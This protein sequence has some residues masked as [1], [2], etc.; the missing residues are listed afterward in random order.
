MCGVDFVQLELINFSSCVRCAAAAVYFVDASARTH[1]KNGHR[2]AAAPFAQQGS[3]K[4]YFRFR[5]RFRPVLF[6]ACARERE[7]ILQWP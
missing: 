6:W 7:G 3:C 2:S 4:H 1:R 5:A